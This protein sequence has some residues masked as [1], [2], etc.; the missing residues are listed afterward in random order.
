M[1]N[2]NDNWGRKCAELVE[3]IKSTSNIPSICKR[4]LILAFGF[5]NLRAKY[6]TL[7]WNW[8]NKTNCSIK[9]AFCIPFLFQ[10]TWSGQNCRI[11][12]CVSLC[13][14]CSSWNFVHGTSSKMLLFVCFVYL[15]VFVCLFGFFFHWGCRIAKGSLVPFGNKVNYLH[16][17][18]TIYIKIKNVFH[19][20]VTCASVA[21][22]IIWLVYIKTL[23]NWYSNFISSRYY[24]KYIS[25]LQCHKAAQSLIRNKCSCCEHRRIIVKVSFAANE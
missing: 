2:D 4:M 15:F 9:W 24:Q 23:A 6:V 16:V 12:F 18:R 17:D 25:M 1:D 11:F 7:I 5:E 8:S 20:V 3:Y 14:S 21:C 13:K 19:F 22:V 10:L